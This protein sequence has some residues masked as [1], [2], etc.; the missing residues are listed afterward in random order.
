MYQDPNIGVPEIVRTKFLFNVRSTQ[1][2]IL[3]INQIF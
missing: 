2:N 3:V 1:A